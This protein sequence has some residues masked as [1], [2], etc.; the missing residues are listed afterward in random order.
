MRGRAIL[1]GGVVLLL[2]SA[3]PALGWSLCDEITIIDTNLSVQCVWEDSDAQILCD[4]ATPPPGLTPA[5][6]EI[7]CDPEQPDGACAHAPAFWFGI[8]GAGD[9]YGVAPG[10]DAAGTYLDVYRRLAGTVT[11]EHVLR[12]TERTEPL[13]GEVTKI[14]AAGRWQVDVA[15]G[16]IL[17]NLRG[18]CQTAL[19]LGQ[20]DN[21]EHLALV[22]VTGLPSLL[23]V[24]LTY[25]PGGS[26]SFRIP[27][28]PEGLPTGDFFDLYAG[29]VETLPDL[30][31]AQTVAC[32][33]ASGLSPGDTV[34]VPDP[35]PDPPA[36]E[37]RYYLMAVTSGTERRAGRERISGVLQG[38]DASGLPWCP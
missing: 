8:D 18:S 36:W 29:A 33:V 17:F 32:D 7:L 30:S 12:I 24:A 19:C 27:A 23:D 38:R 2:A 35:L 13:P 9:A 34:V 5:D 28:L 14:F 31:Q 25:E 20:G 10:D 11:D 26:V 21:K 6:C 1:A 4:G 3:G 37:P 16:E 22:R 15:R